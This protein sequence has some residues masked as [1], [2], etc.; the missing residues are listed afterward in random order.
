[1]NYMI[2]YTGSGSQVPQVPVQLQVPAVGGNGQRTIVLTPPAQHPTSNVM[3]SQQS[4]YPMMM[5][6]G[7]SNPQVLYAY[8][9]GKVANNHNKTASSSNSGLGPMILSSVSPNGNSPTLPMSIRGENNGIGEVF[10]V[11]A[12]NPVGSSTYIPNKS[13][14]LQ[15]D[16]ANILSSLQSSGLQI[17]KTTNTT[18]AAAQPVS[19]PVVGNPPVQGV[20]MHADKTPV[21]NFMSSLQAAGLNVVENSADGTMSICLPKGTFAEKKV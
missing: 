2:N 6:V 20:D 18:T 4:S 3:N 7:G 8:Q 9:G 14:M 11:Q 5:Q 21:S 19:I 12:V 10:N 16:L 1:M 17:V 13:Q 15:G